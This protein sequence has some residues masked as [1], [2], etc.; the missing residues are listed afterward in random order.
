MYITV[1]ATVGTVVGQQTGDPL[2]AFVAGFISHL[3]LDF[4]PHGDTENAGVS[5]TRNKL[6]LM[7]SIDLFVLGILT[8]WIINTQ[9]LA[10]FT[11][12]MLMGALGGV[13]PDAL[14]VPHYLSNRKYF[15]RYQFAHDLFHNA[16]SD[17]WDMHYTLGILFQGT[18]LITLLSKLV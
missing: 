11:L 6:I 13:V 14:Q 16:I 10:F 15:K 7:G 12:P 3:L 5:Y 4:I 1:H 2:L 8:F 18:I 9:S 17:R